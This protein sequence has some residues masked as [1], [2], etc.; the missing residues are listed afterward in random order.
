MKPK[1]GSKRGQK[2]DQWQKR[3]KEG[4][5]IQ[6]GKKGGKVVLPPGKAAWGGGLSGWKG[7]PGPQAGEGG[8]EY[9]PRFEKALREKS[10][11]GVKQFLTL[12]TPLCAK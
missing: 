6:N 8:G 9:L 11:K 10:N 4:A 7:G 5:P 3:G 1:D 2:C 12:S